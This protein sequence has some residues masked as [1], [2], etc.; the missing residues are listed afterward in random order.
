M[1]LNPGQVADAAD[2]IVIVAV[3][4]L[5]MFHEGVIV[6]ALSAVALVHDE[7]VQAVDVGP[8]AV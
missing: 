1:L 5:I 6:A 8:L 3:P 4:L 2:L 7:G